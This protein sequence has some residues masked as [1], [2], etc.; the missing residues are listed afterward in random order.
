[1]TQHDGEILESM[2]AKNL[3]IC[4]N[5]VDSLRH[6]PDVE[7]ILQKLLALRSFALFVG[8]AHAPNALGFWDMLSHNLSYLRP[9]QFIVV[10]GS[11]G[12]ILHQYAP[13]KDS[14]LHLLN[15]QKIKILGEVSRDVL[16][17]LLA[18]ANVILLPLTL[19]GGSNLKTAEAIVANRPVVATSLAIRGFEFARNLTN[20]AIA[21]TQEQFIAALQAAFAKTQPPLPKDEQ[22]LRHNLYW[23]LTLA[24]LAPLV[25]SLD[26]P[27][28]PAA[29][30]PPTANKKNMS[31]A[32]AADSGQAKA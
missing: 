21:D 14:I 16:I 20:F 24:P 15:E 18:R 32:H 31:I 27:S 9:E 8:S 7:Q 17:A 23:G 28:E 30:V 12:R 25:A 19:G 3:V 1:C 5:G 4:S 26:V 2:G 29:P 10:V 6:K 13:E 22:N 11:V